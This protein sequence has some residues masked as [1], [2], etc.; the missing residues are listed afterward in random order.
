MTKPQQFLPCG[1][2]GA[3]WVGRARLGHSLNPAGNAQRHPGDGRTPVEKNPLKHEVDF[4]VSVYCI[5]FR[6]PKQTGTWRH[7]FQYRFKHMQHWC[8]ICTLVSK[9]AQGPLHWKRTRTHTHVH[10]FLL[11]S[12]LRKKTTG[13][14]LEKSNFSTASASGKSPSAVLNCFL[15]SKLLF[16][17]PTIWSW[18]GCCSWGCSVRNGSKQF[19]VYSTGDKTYTPIKNHARCRWSITWR[20]W[21]SELRK[22]IKM[23][24]HKHRETRKHI[25][26]FSF[27]YNLCNYTVSLSVT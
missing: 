12:V 11:A 25:K 4:E 6:F 24:K 1:F 27:V 26:D 21:H 18:T 16:S 14:L 20:C 17:P 8:P 9:A 23:R 5:L 19:K 10:R 13:I 22:L 15:T 7:W 2:L 3:G